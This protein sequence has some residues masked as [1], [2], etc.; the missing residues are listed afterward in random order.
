M[1]Q[2]FIGGVL[3]MLAACGAAAQ[4]SMAPQSQDAAGKQFNPPPAGMAAIYFYNP[5][6]T[7]PVIS[8][9][10]GPIVIGQL[11]PLTWMRI[12]TSAGWHAMRCVASNSAN[13][14]SITVAP[15]DMRFVEV[16]M[17]TGAPVCTIQEAA[18][19]AGRSGVLAGNRALQPQ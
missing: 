2:G 7:G 6:T 1:R 13:P 16:D 3:V 5:L 8:V 11:G 12:E 17:P 4:V 10:E 9:M 19:D 18:T 15:G 14:S